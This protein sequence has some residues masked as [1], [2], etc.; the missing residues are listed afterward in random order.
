MVR[1]DALL[2]RGFVESEDVIRLFWQVMISLGYAMLS[3]GT[4]NLENECQHI[5]VVYGYRGLRRQAL[6]SSATSFD[7][8][9]LYYSLVV[10]GL[11]STW[12]HGVMK[13]HA[14]MSKSQTLISI[15]IRR[16]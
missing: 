7:V 11:C 10:V 12:F 15:F 8:Q 6:S 9:L 1:M 13:Y 5:Q 3:E 14:Q 16:L 2:N 4:N